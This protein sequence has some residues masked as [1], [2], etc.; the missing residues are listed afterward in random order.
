MQERERAESIRAGK[1][2]KGLTSIG[3]PLAPPHKL[4]KILLDPL[5]NSLVQHDTSHFP[6]PP[7]LP[8]RFPFQTPTRVD[9]RLALLSLLSERP[10][11][12]EERREEVTVAG[13][14][15]EGDGFP[16]RAGMEVD[17]F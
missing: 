14:G 15:S 10:G 16:G 6:S 17:L 7:R 3:I 2:G 1:A 4:L 5:P 13:E 9:D 12:G 11:F 8:E